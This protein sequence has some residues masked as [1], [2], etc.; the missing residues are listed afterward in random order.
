MKILT[1]EKQE[2]I[3]LILKRNLTI[4]EGI[5]DF[6]QDPDE[7]INTKYNTNDFEVIKKWLEED[8]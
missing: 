7:N 4:K 3:L 2:E 6:K 8:E 5:I 1:N